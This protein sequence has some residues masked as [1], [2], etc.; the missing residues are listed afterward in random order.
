MSSGILSAFQAVAPRSSPPPA[1]PFV[2][3]DIGGNGVAKPSSAPQMVFDSRGRRCIPLAPR[4]SGGF[5]IES[6]EI[7]IASTERLK[8]LR[9]TNI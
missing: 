8:A 7:S 4:S 2:E 6:R 5:F 1:K 3:K 9:K